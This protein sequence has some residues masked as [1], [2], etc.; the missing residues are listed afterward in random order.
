[1]YVFDKTFILVFKFIQYPWQ[2]PL[3]IRSLWD[4][5][6]LRA[7]CSPGRTC[8]FCLPCGQGCCPRL[9]K[10]SC[11]W[12]LI[13]L[14]MIELI[15]SHSLFCLARTIKLFLTVLKILLKSLRPK[16]PI[17][18]LWHQAQATNLSC[19]TSSAQATSSHFLRHKA[20]ATMSCLTASGTSYLVTSYGIRP[21]LCQVM[22]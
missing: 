1:M 7:F 15:P 22:S 9:D 8:L 6:F 11:D 21:K 18:V 3:R 4:L 14:L 17:N 2:K 13:S 5:T 12:L 20:Q 10:K 19:L 16:L